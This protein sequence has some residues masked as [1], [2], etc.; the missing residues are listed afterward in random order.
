MT[1]VVIVDYLVPPGVAHQTSHAPLV[2]LCS[3]GKK[4]G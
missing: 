2:L 3:I 1:H 4:A